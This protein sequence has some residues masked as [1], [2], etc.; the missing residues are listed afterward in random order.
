MIGK[1]SLVVFL[2][3]VFWGGAST[4]ESDPGESPKPILLGADV[5]FL[6]QL[7]E[8]GAVYTT[9]GNPGEAMA[10][11][12]AYGFNS[13]RLR[14]W[15]TPAE[16][17]NDLARTVKMARRARSAGMSVMLDIHYSDTWADPGKQYKPGAWESL[18]F[19]ELGDSVYA[20]TRDVLATLRSEGAPPEIVQIGNEITPGFLWDDGRV[21]G[22]FGTPQQWMQFGELLRAAISG[23]RD[24]LEPG[25]HVQTMIHI[26]RGG[27]A[28]AAQWFFDHL[29]EEKVEFDLIGLSYYPWWHGSLD[30]LRQTMSLLAEQYKKPIMVVETAYPW[31]LAWF[32]DTHN[33]VGLES[34]LHPGYPATM[35]GQRTFLD[36]VLKIVRDTPGDLGRGVFYWSPEWIA[37][38]GVGSA[39]ENVTLFDQRGEIHTGGALK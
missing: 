18:P 26:D 37:V 8:N 33:I 6:D 12:R 36:A 16:G 25:D 2:L 19:A 28:S 15:H 5:S 11:L 38:E 14:L 3:L 1:G 20:Y 22:S 27:D 10:I 4:V 9:Q 24:A 35:E 31:T 34:Q 7:E 21:G 30:D 29:A 39:W 13:V 32:D 17:Y 23:V